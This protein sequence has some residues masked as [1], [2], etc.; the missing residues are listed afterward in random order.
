MN[1]WQ[2]ICPVTAIVIVVLVVGLI[3]ER[4]EQRRFKLVVTGSIAWD[5][6]HSTNSVHLAIVEPE[7]LAILTEFL[8]STGHVASV[9][10]GDEQK[11]SR[12]GKAWS[13]FVLTNELEQGLAIRLGPDRD[14]RL[15]R[16][17]SYRRITE[18]IGLQ[19]TPL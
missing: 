18:Q 12:T 10:P 3:H 15:F 16:V 7:L 6:V 14:S 11:P 1:K 5:L 2:L 17:V 4:N 9:F 13:S 8:G 19:R